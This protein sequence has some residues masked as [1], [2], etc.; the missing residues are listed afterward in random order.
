[1]NIGGGLQPPPIARAS[2]AEPGEAHPEL[3][4]QFIVSSQAWTGAQSVLIRPVDR[5][6]LQHYTH[7]RQIALE[8]VSHFDSPIAARNCSNKERM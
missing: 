5:P 2:G 4:A 8:G 3:L 1:M 6:S 7:A